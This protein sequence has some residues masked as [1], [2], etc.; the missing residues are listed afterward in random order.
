MVA[1]SRRLKRLMMYVCGDSGPFD[2]YNPSFV[3]RQKF[4]LELLYI[5][6][7]HPMSTNKVCSALK[8][9]QKQAM[10]LLNSWAEIKAIREES[11]VYHVN[12]AI[13]TKED[14][15]IL[16]QTSEPIA[17][18]LADRIDTH[19]RRIISL[20]KNFSAAK[21][22]Q[23]EKLLFAALGCF[24]LDWL[25]LKTLEEE[26]LLVKNKP[27]PGNRNYLLFAREEV[28]RK[29][30]LQLYDKMYWGS[31]SDVSD[32]YTFTSFGDHHGMRYAFPDVLWT[33]QASPKAIQSFFKSPSW[34]I[35]KLST[36]TQFC[37]KKMLRDVAFLLFRLN[38][39]GTISA[40]EI[41]ENNVDIW[42]RNLVRLLKDMNYIVREKGRLKL[43]YP[44]F[45]D[46]DKKIVEQIADI[47]L[48]LATQTIR[49][50]YSILE[51]TL[52]NTT[53][54]RNKVALNEVLN[55]AWHWIFAQTNKILAEKGFLYDPP[56]KRAEEA[57]YIAWVAKFSFL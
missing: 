36:I 16:A 30:A 42:M 51:R 26:R 52:S 4:G 50:N 37:S 10:K 39:E 44:I 20:A 29:T 40:K 45:A 1:S 22:V 48:P 33:L 3:G 18:E 9:S 15:V 43:N 6:N 5:L 53:P 38:A 13:F 23:T 8:I 11:G 35:E 7:K 47:I 41:A 14:L 12:F 54:A 21:Q 57:R 34:I 17:S 25:G 55:E 19:A 28:D 32:R 2:G 31:H 27:Q 24:I 56:K 46:D 49:Q